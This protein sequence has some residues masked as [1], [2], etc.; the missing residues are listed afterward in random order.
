MAR[1]HEIPDADEREL[2][3]ADAR[4]R[5]AALDVS[6]SFIVQAPAGSGKTELLIQRYL[7]LLAT[8]S[9]PEEVVAITFTNKAANEMQARIVDALERARRGETAGAEHQQRTAAAASR[10]LERDAVRDWR[11]LDAPRRMRIQTLDAFCASVT[12]L[13]PISSGLGGS[14]TT[15]ADA[16]MFDLYRDAAAATLDWLAADEPQAAAVTRLLSHLDNSVADYIDYL[17]RMLAK[18]D[19]WLGI[20]GAGVGADSGDDASAARAALEADIERQVCAQLRLARERLVALGGAAER[21]LLSY[22]GRRLE[23]A[24]GEPQP[25]AALAEDDWPDAAAAD[26]GT[27]RMIAAALLTKQGEL[28]RQVDKNSG[29]PP[30]DDGEK[31]AFSSWLE[32]LRG[33]PGLAD[34]L[35]AVREL[36]DARYRDEQWEALLAIFAVLPLAVGELKRL[37]TERGVTDH[38]EVAQA[39]SAALGS[40]DDP[41]ELAMLLDYRIRHLLV[42]EMQDTSIGQYRLLAQLTAGWE[43]G[44]GRTLFCVGDPMQSIYRFRDAEVGQFV[45]ARTHGIGEARLESLVLRRNFRSGEQLVHWFNDVFARV[46]PARDDIATGAIAYSPCVSV[47]AHAGLGS[48]TV[49]ALVDADAAQEAECSA[50]IVEGCLAAD[51]G[52]VAVLVRGRS[53]LPQLLADLRRRGIPCRA[54]EIDRL[55]D[56][57]EIIDLL[58]LTRALGH[59]GDRIAWLALLRAP[60]CGMTWRDL[61]RLVQ[62]DRRST[63]RELAAEP[64]RLAALSADGRTRLS[65][66]FDDLDR[67]DRA[68]RVR[69]LRERIECLWLALGGAAALRT[70]EQLDNAYRFLDVLEKLESAGTLADVAALEAQLDD[71][72]VSSPG[73]G[74]TR[75]Q[76]MT[77]HKAKGLQFDHVVLHALGRQPASGDKDMLAWLTLTHDDG[78]GGLVLSPPGPRYEQERDP[79]HRFIERAAEESDGY[80]LARLLYVSCTRAVTSLHLVASVGTNRHGS[81]LATPHRR[82]L[83]HRLW[84]L[85]EPDFEAAFAAS[86][87][88]DEPATEE[89]TFEAP[90]LTRLDAAAP[91]PPEPPPAVA[92][93]RRGAD[94]EVDYE[95]V[96][97]AARHAGTIVHRWLQRMAEGGVSADRLPPDVIAISRRWARALGV[98]DADLDTVSSRVENALKGVLGDDRGRWL[99]GGDGHAELRLTGLEEGAV[100]SIAIDRVR[101]DDD[102]VHWLVDYKTS[103]HEGGDLD[104]FLRQEAD[105]YRGQLRRYRDIYAGVADAPLRTALYFPLLRRF[106]EVDV[107]PLP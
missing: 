14:L 61:H 82:S 92:R 58:A 3:V 65:R 107:G 47:D 96:G 29:F 101:F 80:E 53:Q 75:V 97:S 98:A 33:E 64:E 11:L 99:L 51:D 84:P 36:P 46:L 85:V 72:R 95:W 42:D 67:H 89:N 88:S 102:G 7:A 9:E 4:A 91:C 17:A 27:W 76:V 40:V 32:R 44:D 100:V 79:L 39:A 49:H 77:M 6:R 30:R 73:D 1:E 103:T 70:T 105:R 86:G 41:G 12:R 106:V 24:R 26:A 31:A 10:V 50:D 5:D 87:G 55:T 68:H 19:Q 63:V 37:F 45:A 104:G 23:E 83:L 13:L 22:A 38:V 18:R 81:E 48:V 16:G 21:S 28:R 56:L 66:F 59:D 15:S 34:L 74:Q 57:P 25:L 69:S 2:L 94:R 20:V 8:V 60:W 62:N 35:V 71:E 54:I 90:R 43:P 52:E 78:S 93:S